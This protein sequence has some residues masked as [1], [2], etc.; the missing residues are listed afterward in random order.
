MTMRYRNVFL[1]NIG[2]QQWLPYV[3]QYYNSP[4]RTDLKT[5]LALLF[6]VVVTVPTIFVRIRNIPLRNGIE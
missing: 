1:F 4:P 6:F 2:W 5:G 3:V